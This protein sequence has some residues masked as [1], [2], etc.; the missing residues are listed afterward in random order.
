MCYGILSEEFGDLIFPPPFP[1]QIIF[2]F[3]NFDIFPFPNFDI[4]SFQII[5]PFPN[6]SPLPFPNFDQFPFPTLPIFIFFLLATPSKICYNYPNVKKKEVSFPL[7][8][9]LTTPEERTAAAALAL[10]TASAV[11]PYYLTKLADY[12]LYADHKTRSYTTPNRQVTIDKREL[13]FEGLSSKLETGEDGLYGLITED[14]NIIFS[15]KT[16]ITEEDIATIPGLARLRAEITKLEAQI[17]VTPRGRTRFL[18]NKQLREMR[19]DQYVLKSVYRKP[20]YSINLIRSLSKLDLTEEV[21]LDETNNP[22]STALIN[23]YTPTHISLLLSN[24]SRLKQDSYSNFNS[25]MRWLLIDLED[26]IDATLK[27]LYPKYFTI[28]V[29]KIDGLHNSAIQ[30][31]ILDLYNIKHSV[32]YISFLWRHKIPELI[33]YYAGN[34]WLD[35]HFTSEERGRWKKC[36]RCGQIKLMHPRFFSKNRSSKDGF[37]SIC[38]E[39]RNKKYRKQKEE[40]LGTSKNSTK[41]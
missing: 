20:I 19:Q 4:S 34:Q 28:L 12:I 6:F 15:P 17:S 22:Y 23:L 9:S 33:A 2:S 32:E 1:L 30:Q 37:Y 13:S 25:D 16:S 36:S 10:T 11:T 38:K 14:K 39:C 21:D 29:D 40:K 27:P 35:H 24:Y 5:F 31:H 41:K 8:Y 3:Q 7:D 26:I 18:L